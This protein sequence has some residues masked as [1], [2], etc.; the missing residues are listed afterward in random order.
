MSVG[1]LYSTVTGN[2][3]AVAGYIEAAGGTAEMVDIDDADEATCAGFD[4]LIVGAPTWHTGA[5]EQRTGTGWDSFLYDTLPSW[6]LKG[7]KVAVFG[8]GDSQSYADNF[9]DAIGELHECFKGVGA[10]M[11][12]SVS[13]DGYS[14]EE[15]KS[16]AGGKFLGLPCDEDNESDMSE[17]RVGAWVEQ[18]K[19][20]GMAF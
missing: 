11:I 1:L 10:D 17:E 14:F 12:G 3:E 9:C 8:V 16:V 6:N 7:K 18:L 20:E 19:G 15:S 13:T 5:D 4:G 2:T